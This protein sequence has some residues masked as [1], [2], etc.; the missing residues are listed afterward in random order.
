MLRSIVRHVLLAPFALA[1]VL[2][3]PLVK[4]LDWAHDGEPAF[5]SLREELRLLYG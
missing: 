1:V 2:L 3:W 5:G 4:A